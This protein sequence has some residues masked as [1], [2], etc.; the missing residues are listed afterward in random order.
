MMLLS[1]AAGLLVMGLVG[2][3]EQDGEETVSE[4]ETR[5]VPDVSVTGELVPAVWA[6]VSA[7]RGGSVVE[8]LVE[9]GD[10][11]AAGDVLVR[12][13]AADAELALEQADAALA[14][15]QAQMAVLEA[16]ARPAELSAA[17]AGVESAE[18]VLSQATAE[19]SR[20][21]A[22]ALSAEIAAAESALAGAEA[23]WKEAQL[24][25]DSVQARADELDDWMEQEAAL[26]LQAAEQG[27]KAAQ[28]RLTLARVTVDARLREADAA[29]D[30]AVAGRDGAQAQLDLLQAGATAEQIAV[31]QAG[32]SQAQAALDAA[33]LALE[34]TEVRAPFAGTVGMVDTRVGALVVSGQPL[35]T[36][37]DLDT[38]RVETTDL[39]EIDVVKVY[40]GQQVDV[41]FD[42][43]P[44]QV[45]AGEV[46]RISPMAA[47]GSGGVNYTVVI[48]L[49]DVD[50]AVKWGM[51]AFVDI[52]VEE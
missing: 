42:A 45:F 3:T 38:L 7:Q 43:L 10:D 36:L 51:T 19:R 41:S 15:A 22:G 24:Y 39:D 25:Y 33:M 27:V 18:A 13:D 49:D 23:L 30:G 8:V 1:L 48:A 40:V 11:V 6:N 37:G 20:L 47:P 26:R 34:R 2:C 32:L 28:M 16:P 46:T 14:A 17:Q 4:A 50:P 52:E 44:E 21:S 31:A 35:V 9:P 29:V 5:V 12:L